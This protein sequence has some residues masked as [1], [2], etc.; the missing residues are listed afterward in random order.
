MTAPRPEDR[1]AER[2]RRLCDNNRSAEQE[3]EDRVAA[4]GRTAGLDVPF[5]MTPPADGMLIRTL[6]RRGV[7]AVLLTEDL[8]LLRKGD[9][10]C[11]IQQ[12]EMTLRE[13]GE[14]VGEEVQSLA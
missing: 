11:R 7:G 4:L 1:H 10:A 6:R 2:L 13:R 9:L 12:G 8:A 3:L 5:R 14:L